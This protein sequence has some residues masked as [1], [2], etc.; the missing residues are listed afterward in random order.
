[1]S[2]SSA[3]SSAL[4]G[5]GNN[6]RTAEVIASNVA[7][8][9]DASYSRREFDNGLVKRI[10]NPVLLQDRR[11]SDADTGQSAT[12]L[13]HANRIESIFGE[14]DDPTSLTGALAAFDSA[15]LL[16]SSDPSSEIR[17][18]NVVKTA[19]RLT[20]AFNATEGN[21]QS[22]REQADAKI[23]AQIDLLNSRLTEVANLNSSISIAKHG[24]TE[25]SSLMDQRQRAIDDIAQMVPIKT[26]ARDRGELTIYTTGGV[27]LVGDSASEIGFESSPVVTSAMT[28]GNGLLSGLTVNGKS[29][30]THTGGPFAGGSI[31]AQFEI[32][33]E[34]VPALQVELDEIAFDLAQKF[35]SNGPDQT[36][37][38][39]FTGLF[40]DSGAIPLQG[41]VGTAGRLQLNDRVST[42]ESWR[43]RDG[44]YAAT[45]G[46]VGNSSL[47]TS[48]SSALQNTQAPTSG[49]GANLSIGERISALGERAVS[50]RVDA[51]QRDEAAQ[52]RNT[53]LR[54]LENVGGVDT[55]QELQKLL[56]VEQSY[57]ANAQVLSTM[58]DLINKLLEM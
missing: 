47:L 54:E 41:D 14:I 9:G 50:F 48:L 31:A 27:V 45:Q 13:D 2:I 5:M 32:R 3:I 10:A 42:A 46:E 7:N 58:D 21:L 15:L 36:I 39:G 20:A 51:L 18:E 44:I 8:A 40:T 53:T 35:G 30:S 17:L 29:I 34:I 25:V 38:S 23:N 4:V 57:A 24:D 33:D 28:I 49:S 12:M 19:G 11:L 37:A 55:D 52:S 22:V 1:M 56:M 26:V 6:I 43:M 16:A